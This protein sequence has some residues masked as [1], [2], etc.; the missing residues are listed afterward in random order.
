MGVVGQRSGRQSPGRRWS[1]REV[2]R[3]GGGEGGTWR[4]RSITACTVNDFASH[5][6]DSQ[7][8]SLMTQWLYTAH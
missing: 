8:I 4:G 7:L 6:D 1:G 2:E 5:Y 3:E